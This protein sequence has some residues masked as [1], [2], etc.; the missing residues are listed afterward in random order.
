MQ[1]ATGILEEQKQA[2]IDLK[3]TIDRLKHE[4]DEQRANNSSSSVL[5]SRPNS[6]AGTLRPSFDEELKK[7][8]ASGEYEDDDSGSETTADGQ[9]IMAKVDGLSGHGQNDDNEVYEEIRIKTIK[10]RTLR[11]S[12]RRFPDIII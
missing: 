6:L 8:L 2:N 3:L 11:V 10:R 9:D 1:R 5:G 7:A 4:L 12:T